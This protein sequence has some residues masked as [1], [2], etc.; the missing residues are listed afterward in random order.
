LVTHWRRKVAREA[1]SFTGLPR[2]MELRDR[3]LYAAYEPD[4]N[5]TLL[6]TPHFR[7][8]LPREQ[9]VI[10][11]RKHGLTVALEPG[12]AAPGGR[13]AGGH[14]VLASPGGIGVSATLADTDPVAGR[15]GADQSGLAAA[16]HAAPILEVS[17]REPEDASGA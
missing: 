5:I 11:D 12:R 17:D 8:R 7:V 1:H 3:T 9:W 4:H 2:F 10:H 14:P 13:G 6:L 15:P 16:M